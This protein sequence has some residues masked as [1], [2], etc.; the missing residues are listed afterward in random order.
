VRVLRFAG[1]HSQDSAIRGQEFGT[2]L[3]LF[4]SIMGRARSMVPL[5]SVPRDGHVDTASS[6]PR[7]RS[8]ALPVAVILGLV[9]VGVL[10]GAAEIRREQAIGALPPQARIRILGETVRELRSVC[11]EGY[12]ANGPVRDHCIDEARFVL[13]LPECGPDCRTAANAVL[14]RTRR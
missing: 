9:V 1:E 12:A 11:L 13:L 4:V 7:P 6:G 3:A 10:I 8:H 5:R 2:R 14:P